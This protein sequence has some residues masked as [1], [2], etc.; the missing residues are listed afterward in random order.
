MSERVI[1]ATDSSANLPDSLVEELD[2]RVVPICLNI[3]D[4]TYR[5]GVDLT[6][7]EFYRL[8]RTSTEVPKTSSPSVADFL[9]VY[10]KAIEDG[11]EVVA[12]H[13]TPKLSS[14]YRTAVMTSQMID[15][16]AKIRIV[17]SGCS[18][19]AQGFVVL[20]AARA[21]AA[22]ADLEGVVARAEEMTQKVRF[23]AVLET[24]DYLYRGGRIGNAAHLVGTTLRIKPMVTVRQGK[25]ELVAVLRTKS[26]AF[27]RM[28]QEIEREA[29]GRPVHAGVFHSDALEE[30][31]TLQHQVAEHVECVE[32]FVTEF[33]PVMGAHAGPGLVGVAYYVDDDH[34]I[35]HEGARKS[36]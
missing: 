19:M 31:E 15:D 21:A 18:T 29:Q 28:I 23:L 1:V 11:N 12:I 24:L 2:I 6:P 27:R 26:Q 16:A 9:Q 4:R 33:T 20:E 14:I 10:T 13:I 30:A 32:L 35:E 22:G 17:D 5:D 3:G 7:T 25:V 34:C 8:L 36:C